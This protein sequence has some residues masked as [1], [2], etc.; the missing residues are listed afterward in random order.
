MY[1]CLSVTGRDRLTV[2]PY[3]IEQNIVHLAFSAVD[4]GHKYMTP[5]ND[6]TCDS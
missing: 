1:V 4:G 2:C 6:L 5:A 3:S